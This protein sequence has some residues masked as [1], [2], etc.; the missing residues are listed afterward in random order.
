MGVHIVSALIRLKSEIAEAPKEHVC[1]TCGKYLEMVFMSSTCN[2]RR[3]K[4]YGSLA[5]CNCIGRVLITKDDVNPSKGLASARFSLGSSS[6]IAITPYG[7][8]VLHIYVPT[9]S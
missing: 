8:V 7:E 1:T 2:P 4:F 6:G 3:A 9:G 5:P